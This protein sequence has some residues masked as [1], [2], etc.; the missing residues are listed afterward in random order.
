[1]ASVGLGVATLAEIPSTVTQTLSAV[2]AYTVSAGGLTNGTLTVSKDWGLPGDE[3]TVTV[4]AA[5]GYEIDKVYVNGDEIAAV[6]G[7]YKFT[8]GAEDA[9]VTAD[10]T[11]IEYDITVGTIANGT[12]MPSKNKGTVG[13]EITLTVTPA[14][15]YVISK[16]LV[17]GDEIT[18]VNG[19][20]K[21]TMGAEN[22]AV[23]ATFT[24]IVYYDVTVGTIANGTVTPSKNKGTAG[25]E[26]TL[27]VTPAEGYKL[28]KV[29]VNGDE[30]MA[31]NGIY[32]FTLGTEDVT[33]TAEFA[34]VES[35]TGGG[36]GSAAGA[37][38]AAMFGLMAVLASGFV[39]LRGRKAKIR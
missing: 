16:V 25:E 20:Y 8:V 27:T 31:V 2:P 5:A 14:A 34:A 1:V 33:V 17:N 4:T 36:C 23:S 18:A 35:K 29:L 10:F 15:G 26:I 11:A 12:V 9:A 37:G 32:K 24:E 3:I 22:A 39:V 28:S 6:S 21:F 30:I 19:V 38:T 13:Q 7:V